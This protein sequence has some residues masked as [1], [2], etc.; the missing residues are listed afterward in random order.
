MNIKNIIVSIIVLISAFVMS[1][2]IHY[3]IDNKSLIPAIFVLAIFIISLVTKGYLYGIIAS[4]ISVFI[5]NYAFTFPYFEFALEM[6][7]IEGFISIVLML[8]V[9]IL[10]STLTTQ[11]KYQEE[12]RL[13][14]EKEKMRSN[15]LRSISH[16]IR[17]PLTS[18]YGSCSILI[19][20]FDSIDKE[21]QIQ[22]LKDMSNDATWLIRLVENLLS[23]TRIDSSTVS[24]KKTDTVI[25]ELIDS[26]LIKFNKKYPLQKVNVNIPTEFLIVPMDSIL[27]E[28]VIINLLENSVE[29]AKGMKNLNLNIFVNGKEVIFE[30]DDDGC[31]FDKSNLNKINNMEYSLV[32]GKKGNMGIG[33][34]ICQTIIKAH[35]GILKI[36]D[37]NG[38]GTVVSFTLIRGD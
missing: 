28:Q 29:H 10:T 14:S 27:I 11:I 22:L 32:D 18:I 16:D 31:G 2:L 9:T 35:G 34:S 5:I 8:I 3:M 1:L 17:T 25:E 6:T 7:L 36:V 38:K 19:E 13:E 15:L 37:K 33:L 21:K 12:I 24:V 23:I 4:I 20:G 30:V 26:V